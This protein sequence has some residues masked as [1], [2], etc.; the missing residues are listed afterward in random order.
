MRKSLGF[1]LGLSASL[2][3][4]SCGSSEQVSQPKVNIDI[5]TEDLPQ[6]VVEQI[7][8]DLAELSVEGGLAEV[9]FEDILA[10]LPEIDV[11]APYV[12]LIV[13]SRDPM[14]KVQ[15]QDLKCVAVSTGEKLSFKL[16]D[17]DIP[18]LG[19]PTV[20]IEKNLRFEYR[21]L[22]DLSGVEVCKIEGLKARS[23]FISQNVDGLILDILPEGGFKS[24]LVDVGLGGDYPSKNCSL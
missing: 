3:L 11:I 15:C 17:V 22:E 13:N 9:A 14:V 23:G 2:F 21:F 16:E 18:V 19:K 10:V 5:P 4:A 12:D 1:C 24:A 7:I 8:S 20:V 6:D